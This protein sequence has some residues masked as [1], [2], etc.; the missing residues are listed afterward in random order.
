MSDESEE[1]DDGRL[2][3]FAVTKEDAGEYEC[4][5]PVNGDKRRMRLIVLQGPP[6]IS[7]DIGNLKH[8]QSK[9]KKDVEADLGGSVELYCEFK[10]EPEIEWKKQDGV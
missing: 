6:P 4:F 1:K 3:I 5:N 7:N 9:Y 2:I 8:I 10:D